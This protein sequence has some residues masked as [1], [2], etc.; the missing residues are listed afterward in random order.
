MFGAGSM[1]DSKESNHE[2]MGY[3]GERAHGKHENKHLEGKDQH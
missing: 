2:K 1:K 3:M